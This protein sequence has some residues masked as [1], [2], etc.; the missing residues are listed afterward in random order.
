MDRV[1]QGIA[2]PQEK[3]LASR[4]PQIVK[5]FPGGEPPKSEAKEPFPGYGAVE[6]QDHILNGPKSIKAEEIS[7]A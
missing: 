1:K 7:N 5:T 2:T 4:A 3:L 6:S